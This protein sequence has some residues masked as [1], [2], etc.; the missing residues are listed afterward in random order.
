M[1]IAIVNQHPTDM[2][3]GSEIQCDIIART[4]TEF[5]HAVDYIAVNGRQGSDYGLSYKVRA[6]PRQADAI[7]DQVI[8]ARPDILYWRFNKHCFARAAQRIRQA[9]I[10]IVFSVSHV[11][12]V[13]RFYWQ[14]EAWRNG[15]LRSARRALKESWRLYREHRGFDH[16]DALVSNNPDNLGASPIPLKAFIPNS[17]VTAGQPFDWPRPFCLWVANIKDRKQPEKYLELAAALPDLGVDFLMVGQLQ[18]KSYGPL[19]AK[20]PANFHYLGEKSLEEVNGMLAQCRF[21]VHTCH[22]EGFSNNF[23]QAWLQ[24]RTVVSL[25]FDPGGLLVGESLGLYANSSMETFVAQTRQLI[26]EPELAQRMGEEAR[27]Y[28]EAHFSPATNV[29]QLEALFR[30]VLTSQEEQ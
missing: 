3:G 13:T 16:V 8:A 20:G 18:S 25:A 24:G 21:L 6:V 9:G 14:P 12:D 1:R 4:L 7:A 22:P 28:A 30:Q 11:R 15:G 10:P 26:D 29:R 19:L 2:L 23:I 17:M 5:G 27:R